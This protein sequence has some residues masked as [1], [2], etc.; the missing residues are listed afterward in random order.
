MESYNEFLNRVNA[1]ETP[2][3]GIAQEDFKPS[4][5]VFQ[6]VDSNNRFA[7]FFGDTVVF[8]LSVALK[9]LV[10]YLTHMLHSELPN[11]FCE[12][13][14]DSTFHL[15]LHDLVNSP[16]REEVSEK[17]DSNL[18]RIVDT[19]ID[20]PIKKTTID[21]RPVCVMNMVNTSVVLA[22]QPVSEEDYNKIISV[23]EMFEE[24]V[25]LPYKF[26]PHITL[27]YYNRDG[28]SYSDVLKLKATVEKVN[29]MISVNPFKNQS[30][31]T[32]EDLY[33]QRF[34]SMNYYISC[35]RLAL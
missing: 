14:H 31:V 6:K 34:N 30:F 9:N 1:F 19:I 5:S 35:L 24:I 17:M 11:C 7:H 18:R 26:T 27:A 4:D 32:T 16:S 22:L 12:R 33:Y 25:K 23:Y 29:Q 3:F 13:L 20:N 15:T 8:D 28:F 21:L 10:S 2:T